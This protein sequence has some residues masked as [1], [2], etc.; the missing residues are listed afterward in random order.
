[1]KI[2]IKWTPLHVKNI[3]KT[4]IYA[5]FLTKKHELVMTIYYKS[6]SYASRYT[7]R[8]L[9]FEDIATSAKFLLVNL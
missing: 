6:Y 4:H 5:H 2:I 8:I 3:A 1:M 9:F 7:Y